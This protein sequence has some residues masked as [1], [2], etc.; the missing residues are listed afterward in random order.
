VSRT[1]VADVVVDG[2][3]RAGTPHLVGVP[4]GGAD[5]PLLDAARALGL[6]VVL[7]SHERGACVIAAVTGDLVDAPGAVAIGDT[8]ARVSAAARGALERAPFILITSGRP[9]A[10]PG[11][12]ETLRA[13]AESAAHRIAHAARLAMTEPRGPVHLDIPADVARRATVPLATSCRPDPTPYPAIE[14]LDHA[15][16]ALSG[17]SRPLLLAGAHCR[18]DDAAQWLRAFVEALPAPLLTTARAKGTLP[19]PH[20]LMLGVLGVTGS[21]AHLLERA[22]LVVA[23]GLDVLEPIPESCW[24]AAPL[25]VFGPAAVPDGRAPAVQV[26]GEVSAIV[27]ELAVRLRDK[28]RADWDVAELD[29]LRR[30]GAAGGA[31]AGLDAR[32]V[33]LAREMTPAGTIATVDAGEHYMCVAASWHAIAPREFLVSRSLADAGFA[34]PAAIAAHLVHPNRRVVCFTGTRDLAAVS[35]LPTAGR[36][37]ARMAVV[38]FDTGGPDPSQLLQEAASCG[39]SAVAIDSEATFAQALGRALATDRPSLIVVRASG[40]SL[41]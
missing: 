23:I 28:P 18:S 13:E 21:E 5:H 29:R 33:R 15:A 10:M 2:L 3:R 35:E 22:D 25:I 14:A 39:M 31:G 36:V 37:G 1:T 17:A 8:P 41:T 32:I 6:P 4:P 9:S 19:D 27:E 24:S 26:L 38:A 20:P 40:V 12:K 7:A 30:A 11:C 16:R 34:L